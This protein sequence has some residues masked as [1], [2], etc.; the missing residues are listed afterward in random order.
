MRA[1]YIWRLNLLHWKS[2]SCIFISLYFNCFAVHSCDM[3]SSNWCAITY[4]FANRSVLGF[5]QRKTTSVV[6][7]VSCSIFV[8]DCFYSLY[9]C[10]YF[11]R[12]RFELLRLCLCQYFN[13]SPSFLCGNGVWICSSFGTRKKKENADGK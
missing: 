10:K 9:F 12:W 1:I 6:S 11:L 8:S 5:G 4:S 2:Y 7:S 13:K 3:V